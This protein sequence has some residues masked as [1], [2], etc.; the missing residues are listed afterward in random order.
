MYECPLSYITHESGEIVRQ[1]YRTEDTKRFLFPGEWC[2]QP[3]WFVEAYDLF[4]EEQALEL[5]RQ[6]DGDT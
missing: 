2:D 1:V 5:R 3:A 6:E 4:K